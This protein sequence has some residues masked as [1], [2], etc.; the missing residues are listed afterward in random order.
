MWRG[1][2]SGDGA[3][4]ASRQ[5]SDRRTVPTSGS[6]TNRST[7]ACANRATGECTLRR[8]IGIAACGQ[9]QQ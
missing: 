7:G 5:C 2:G 4:R 9:S 6:P 1:D 3:N 8:I